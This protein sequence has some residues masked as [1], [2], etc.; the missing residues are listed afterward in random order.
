MGQ[1]TGLLFAAIVVIGMSCIV[2]FVWDPFSKPNVPKPN[3][4]DYPSHYHPVARYENEDTYGGRAND[5]KSGSAKLGICDCRCRTDD[6]VILCTT[7]VKAKECRNN[8]E[9]SVRNTAKQ[10]SGLEIK[11]CTGFTS[12]KKAYGHLSCSWSHS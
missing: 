5:N 6:K 9:L 10:C 11:S 4:P 12:D 1:Q 8:I 3:F 2:L 7:A